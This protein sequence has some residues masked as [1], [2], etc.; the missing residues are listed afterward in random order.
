MLSTELE[1]DTTRA[2]DRLV[3]T[4]TKTGAKYTFIIEGSSNKIE[5]AREKF[6]QCV[7][8]DSLA[9][10]YT[11]QLYNYISYQLNNL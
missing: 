4:R 3:P 6:Y 10:V 9:K 2:V 11:V 7:S 1:I 5:A 8:N